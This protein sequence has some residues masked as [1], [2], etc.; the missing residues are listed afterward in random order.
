MPNIPSDNLADAL[1]WVA[2]DPVVDLPAWLRKHPPPL[3]EKLPD[4]AFS[5]H[6]ALCGALAAL[7]PPT[8]LPVVAPLRIDALWG[9]DWEG[10][11]FHFPAL[12]WWQAPGEADVTRMMALFCSERYSGR[13]AVMRRRCLL[14]AFKKI[15]GDAMPEWKDCWAD[16]MEVI[17]EECVPVAG[18]NQNA[19]KRIDLLFRSPAGAREGTAVFCYAVEAKFDASLDNDMALYADHVGKHYPQ[20]EACPCGTRRIAVLGL[21]DAMAGRESGEIYPFVN[22]R[23]LL[24]AWEREIRKSNDLD[25]VFSQFR[26]SIWSKIG[27]LD[28]VSQHRRNYS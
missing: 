19:N 15:L 9:K 21:K 18:G 6:K 13:K 22:W 20:G 27:G 23:Q 11:P 12:F 4:I 1:E 8:R 16:T 3:P 5:L 25:P 7:S 28:V 26:M 17:A 10:H 24:P 2:K 14:G